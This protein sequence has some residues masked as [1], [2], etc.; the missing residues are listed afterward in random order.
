MPEPDGCHAPELRGAKCPKPGYQPPVDNFARS[1]AFLHGA[2]RFGL[3][4]FLTSRGYQMPERLRSCPERP[5]TV[6]DFV[7]GGAKSPNDC[8]PGQSVTDRGG[9]QM[10]ERYFPIVLTW[11]AIFGTGG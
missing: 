4:I 2:A 3:P 6:A 8:G 5:P 1:P 7:V 9:Y 10:P 11:C